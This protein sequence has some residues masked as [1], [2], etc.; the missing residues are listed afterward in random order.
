MIRFAELV[1]GLYNELVTLFKMEEELY[2]SVLGPMCE[3]FPVENKQ[4]KR[5]FS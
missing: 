1:A 3:E 4:K 5:T 2:K